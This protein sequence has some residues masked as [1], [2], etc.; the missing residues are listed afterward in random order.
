MIQ[1]LPR[2]AEARDSVFKRLAS[3]CRPKQHDTFS[4]A[5]V[6]LVLQVETTGPPQN[7]TVISRHGCES[8]THS[9][10]AFQVRRA[11]LAFSVGPETSH[12]W[13]HQRRS[14]GSKIDEPI[15]T[16]SNFER[17]KD[18]ANLYKSKAGFSLSS[19][20]WLNMAQNASQT[21]G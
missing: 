4:W 13:L 14:H 12:P 16:A 5:M 6:N 11:D 20:E 19:Q 18:G 3:F 7:Q 15:G 1:P 2:V 17:S 9:W 21:K 10:S 8:S